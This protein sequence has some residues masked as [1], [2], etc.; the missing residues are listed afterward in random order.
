[1]PK[2]RTLPKPDKRPPTLCWRCP[3]CGATYDTEKGYKPL[4]CGYCLIDRVRV[5]RLV[6]QPK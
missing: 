6:E 3:E 5:V 1:M 2:H 4:N